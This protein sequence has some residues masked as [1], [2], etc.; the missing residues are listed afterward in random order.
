MKY[1]HTN[2]QFH[3]FSDGEQQ[4]LPTQSLLSQAH[5]GMYLH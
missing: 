1:T 5:T 3:L 2:N 4:I